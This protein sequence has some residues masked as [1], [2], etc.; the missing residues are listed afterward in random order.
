MTPVRIFWTGLAGVAA[1]AVFIG[2]LTASTGFVYRHWQA[3]DRPMEL[4]GDRVVMAGDADVDEEKRVL[5]TTD[6]RPQVV[7]EDATYNF[8]R[9]DPLTMASH[10]FCI[11][12]EGEGP[13]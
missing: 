5:A 9:L 2:V 10:T 6:V 7:V 4:D 13:L 3:P 8:G 1:I 11:R 12:N